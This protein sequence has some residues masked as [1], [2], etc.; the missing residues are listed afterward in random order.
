MLEIFRDSSLLFLS[1][2]YAWLPDARRKSAD[3]IV[4]TRLFGRQVCALRGPDAV[5]FFY[6]KSNVRREGALPRPVLDTLCGRGAVHTLDGELHRCRKDMFASLLTDPERIAA[7]AEHAVRSWRESAAR[8]AGRRVVLFDEAAL[9]LARAVC[10]WTGLALS[11]RQTLQLARDCVAMVDGFASVGPRHWRAR[12]ARSCQERALAR[13]VERTESSG[14]RLSTPLEVVADHRETNGL[15]LDPHTVAVELLN[16]IRP[17]IAISWFVTFAAH[18]LHRWPKNRQRLQEEGSENFATALAHETRRYYPFAPFVVGLAAR[19]LHWHGHR[20][21][22]GTMVLLDLYG[23]N[24]DPV[25]WADPYR[26]NPDRFLNRPPNPDDLIPQGGGDTKTGHRCPGEDV[27]VVLLATLVS[28]LATLQYKVV[29][30]DLSIPLN[31]MPTRPRS[32]FVMCPET[33]STTLL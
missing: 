16:I 29:E 32:G 12:A 31:R 3:G 5:Q 33:L 27:T 15:P 11:D 23:Q 22:R 7:L 17:T 20:I 2:G 30:Q 4:H 24:H 28:E 25:L 8:W 18:A 26:F 13:I 14:S 21:S 19:D 6:D 1:R 10:D 9:V